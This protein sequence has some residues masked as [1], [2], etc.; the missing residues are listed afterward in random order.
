[1]T[2]KLKGAKG[3]SRLRRAIIR[4]IDV[5]KNRVRAVL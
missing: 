5:T 2:N 1:M 3:Q 4:C